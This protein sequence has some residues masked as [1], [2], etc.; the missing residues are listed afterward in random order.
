MAPLRAPGHLVARALAI[1]VGLIPAALFAGCGPGATCPA[2][3]AS[4]CVSATD[5]RCGLVC[6]RNA[7]C[8]G[9]DVCVPTSNPRVPGVCADPLWAL[10]NAPCVPLCTMN[11]VCVEWRTMANSCA[12]RCEDDTGC[13][14]RCCVA[15]SDGRTKVCAPERY[16]E[17][18]CATPCAADELCVAFGARPEC[19]RRCTGDE[20]CGPRSCCLPLEGGG[21]VCPPRGDFC[22]PTPPPTCRSLD[23][24]VQSDLTVIPAGEGGC[25]LFGQ[26][27][28]VVRNVCGERAYC[29]A[30]WFDRA[31]G[32]YSDCQNLGLIENNVTVPAGPGRCADA[33]MMDRPFRLRCVDANGVR[34]DA[35]CLGNGPL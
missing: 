13:A 3:Q 31:T 5:C 15:L 11:Q 24:C 17:Q 8:G 19:A 29:L 30:C 4:L 9:R 22:P 34:P 25:G 10:R 18:G 6:E 2:G 14:S 33:A 16:C 26:Y 32:T 21:G 7:D 27:E 35:N 1:V 12:N 28:G 20:A 23:A